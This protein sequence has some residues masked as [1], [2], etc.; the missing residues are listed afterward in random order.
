MAINDDGSVV[1]GLSENTDAQGVTTRRAFRWTTV[2]GMKALPDAIT[3]LH[4]LSLSGNGAI[5]VGSRVDDAGGKIACLWS[6]ALGLVDLRT[7]LVG[8]GVANLAGINLIDA[9]ISKD[10][11]SIA[12]TYQVDGRDAAGIVRGL[13]FVTSNDDCANA[14]SIELGNVSFNTAGSTTDGNNPT[15]QYCATA[16]GSFF[17]D[18]WYSFTPSSTGTFS[19]TTCNQANWTL[20]KLSALSR[21]FD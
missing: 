9:G 11:K 14:L 19:A 1:V 5:V 15:A 6:S 2:S 21:A 18:I 10:G 20:M 17:N 8:L 13:Q 16:E 7:Y 4:G 3:D 12:V